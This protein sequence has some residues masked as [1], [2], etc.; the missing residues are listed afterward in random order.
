M[1]E[2]QVKSTAVKDEKMIWKSEKKEQ[3]NGGG[4]IS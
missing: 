2:F 1:I 3:G 4:T